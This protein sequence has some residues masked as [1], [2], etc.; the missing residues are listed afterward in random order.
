MN[1]LIVGAGAVGQVYGRHLALG[2]ARV[3]YYVREKYAEECRRGFV[4]YPLNRR[5]PRASPVRMPVAADEILTT[6]AEVKALAWDQVYLCMASHALRGPWLGELAAAIGDATVVSLQ[7]GSD[8][9]GVVTAAV[10]EDRVVS[11]MITVISYHAPLAGET[12]PEPGMAYWFPP[13]Q[14]APFSGPRERTRAVVDALRR[15]KLPSKIVRDVPAKVRFP[16][17]LLM[18]LLT[19][20][21]TAQWKLDDLAKSPLLAR[22]RP[23]TLEAFAIIAKAHGTKAPRLL[24]MFARPF[25]LRRGLGI[26]RWI[27][28]F[29]LETYLRVHF[30]KVREQTR[31]FM[32][33]YI[34]DGSRLGRATD[35]LRELEARVAA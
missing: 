33:G 31:M 24:T 9:R 18:V 1:V 29:D 19:A 34:D 32:Q 10:P 30:T 6:I 3:Y 4:F 25:W 5:T 13:L 8:D 28:P 14:P 22:V 12:V 11:G 23:A 27:M 7:P 26:A 16:S 21:E 2:G 15:G 17:A 35:T 20:L